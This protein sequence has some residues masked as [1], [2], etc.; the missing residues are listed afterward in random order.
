MSRDEIAEG[1]RKRELY[2]GAPWRT[3]ERPTSENTGGSTR[4][5]RLESSS[6]ARQ[7]STGKKARTE[8][9]QTNKGKGGEETGKGKSQGKRKREESHPAYWKGWLEGDIKRRRQ[10]IQTNPDLD[11]VIS[12][13]IAGFEVNKQ[14]QS[15]FV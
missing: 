11:T 7:E 4:I 5:V 1:E 6:Q 15:R 8:S 9:Q 10:Q 3:E 12:S 13:T 2:K 14:K